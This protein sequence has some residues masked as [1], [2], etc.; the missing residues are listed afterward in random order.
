MAVFRD[1]KVLLAERAK[2]P[3]ASLLFA[4]GRPRRTGRDVSSR[5]PCANCSRRPASRP[6][7]VGF[8]DHVEVIERDADGRVERHFVVASFVGRWIAGEGV[9]GPEAPGIAWVDPAKAERYPTTPG[10]TG[11][12]DRAARFFAAP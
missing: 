7:F 3:A 5:R 2:P 8:N 12:L 9:V 10:L 1:G 11:I 4:A 6:T